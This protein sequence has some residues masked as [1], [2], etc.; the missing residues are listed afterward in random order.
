MIDQRWSDIRVVVAV[1]AD[2][3]TKTI[4]VLACTLP[5]MDARQTLVEQGVSTGRI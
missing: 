3:P 1:V 5:K 4:A 2:L